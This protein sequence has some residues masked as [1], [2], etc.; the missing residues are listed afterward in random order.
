MTVILPRD[1]TP[2][3]CGNSWCNR[4]VLDNHLA[5]SSLLSCSR[6]R[7]S[8]GGFRTTRAPPPPPAQRPP[9]RRGRGE[10]SPSLPIGVET[11][12]VVGTVNGGCGKSGFW[13]RED[14]VQGG[15]T[16]VLCHRGH[17]HDA[18]GKGRGGGGGGATVYP[19]GTQA[20]EAASQTPTPKP[21][22]ATAEP[23]IGSAPADPAT[24]SAP[25]VPTTGYAEHRTPGTPKVFGLP[26]RAAE[27]KGHPVANLGVLGGHPCDNGGVARE[28]LLYFARVFAHAGGKV[29]QF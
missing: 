6:T 1:S 11:G 16:F 14:T 15:T 24:M 8:K 27:S 26:D 10:T 2:R 21:T 29:G 19:R 20:D 7:D 3:Q 22:L 4:G 17:S 12:E 25:T 28:R 23:A 18:V 9:L 5:L 13:R